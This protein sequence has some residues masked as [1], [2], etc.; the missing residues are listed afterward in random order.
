MKK[1]GP[2]KHTKQF[3]IAFGA[4]G[5][6]FLAW[7]V[8]LFVDTR[9]EHSRNVRLVIA[10]EKHFDIT[11]RYPDRLEELGRSQPDFDLAPYKDYDQSPECTRMP[12]YCRKMGEY[13]VTYP[14]LGGAF[15]QF[16]LGL[17]MDFLCQD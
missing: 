2:H 14:D 12:S 1:P 9:L 11:G 6:L 13:V 17:D 3:M 4:M 5:A 10:L 16:R 7:I 8:Y 15:C